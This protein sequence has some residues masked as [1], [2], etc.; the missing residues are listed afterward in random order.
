[1]KSFVDEDL[2]S[3]IDQMRL[4]DKDGKMKKTLEDMAKFFN[5]TANP[6]NQAAA[7]STNKC[8]SC[9]ISLPELKTSK[10]ELHFWNKFPIRWDTIREDDFRISYHG[11]GYSKYLLKPKDRLDM[12]I[13]INAKKIKFNQMSKDD[14][15]LDYDNT[16][17]GSGIANKKSAINL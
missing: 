4:L 5:P 13:N 2:T 1:L 9:G 10:S 12:N 7:L 6:G 14:I 11:K 16:R 3:K 17:S 15:D 8:G